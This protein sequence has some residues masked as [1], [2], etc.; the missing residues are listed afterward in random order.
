MSNTDRKDTE[1]LVQ[2]LSTKFKEQTIK[3]VD[4]GEYHTEITEGERD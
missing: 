4:I 1:Q 3:D 2:I